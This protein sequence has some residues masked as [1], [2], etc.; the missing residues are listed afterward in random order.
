MNKDE[1]RD[2]FQE[3]LSELDEFENDIK[4]IR[5][6][7]N[8]IIENFDLLKDDITEDQIGEVSSD[9][10]IKLSKIIALVKDILSDSKKLESFIH[11]IKLLKR[12]RE[13]KLNDNKKPKEKSPEE[14]MKEIMEKLKQLEFEKSKILKGGSVIRKPITYPMRPLEN[15]Y[16]IKTNPNKWDIQY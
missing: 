8:L 10:D 7:I 15:P 9:V 13:K 12:K 2:L 3:Q 14:K 4:K 1:I 6:L 11:E 5:N 16:T